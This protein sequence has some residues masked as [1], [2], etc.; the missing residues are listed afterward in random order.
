MKRI[1]I[2]AGVLLMA[3]IVSAEGTSYVHGANGL[4]AK[5]NDTGIYYHHT[6]HLGSTSAV[7]GGAGEVELTS[8]H[9]PFGEEFNSNPDS[10]FTGKEFDSDSGIY[11]FGARYY[12]PE[13]GRFLNSDPAQD[14]I[15]WYS[16]AAGNPLKFI[17]PDGTTMRV[18]IEGNRITLLGTVGLIE[19]PKSGFFGFLRK[20]SERV[21]KALG[22][23]GKKSIKDEWER[24]IRMYWGRDKDED[25]SS[26]KYVPRY[27]KY[28]GREFEIR[29]DAEVIVADYEERHKHENKPEINLVN[30]DDFCSEESCLPPMGVYDYDAKVARKFGEFAGLEKHYKIEPSEETAYKRVP[31]EGRW[32]DLMDGGSGGVTKKSFGELFDRMFRMINID[33]Y[34]RAEFITG[35]NDKGRFVILD[36]KNSKKK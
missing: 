32:D 7:T 14:G 3:G 15:N 29:T 19:P 23:D 20:V 13:T 31:D 21:G 18:V 9:L 2:L 33:E 5:I 1:L 6:D 25:R 28:A 34:E 36:S 4:L 16:Y 17:D 27:G 11:Y 12:S 8:S 10:R 22:Y 35:R 24:A 30:L 26:K